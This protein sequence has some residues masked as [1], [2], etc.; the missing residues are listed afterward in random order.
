V[1]LTSLLIRYTGYAYRRWEKALLQPQQTQERTLRQILALQSRLPQRKSQW[2]GG[3]DAQAQLAHLRQLPLQDYEALPDVSQLTH[4]P[5]LFYELTSGSSGAK[6]RIPYTRPLLQSF[7]HMFLCWAHDILI[8]L[9]QQGRP[10]EGGQV[11]FSVSPQFHESPTEAVD[12]DLGLTDDSDYLTGMSARLFQRFRAAP[13]TLRYL[14]EPQHFWDVLALALLRAPQ[15][16]VISVWSPSFLRV[17]Q[18]HLQRHGERLS[19]LLAQPVLFYENHCFPLPVP[20]PVRQ[21]RLSE[22]LR[23]LARQDL[24][25]AVPIWVWAECFPHLKL[26]SAWGAE[27]AARDF[28]AL[29]T[30]FA[31]AHV[32]EKGLL[33]TEAPITIPSEQYGGFLPLPREVFYE[34]VPLDAQGQPLLQE[35]PLL[36]HELSLG[37]AYELVISQKSGLLRYRL[38]DR[39]R[40]TGLQGLT[41]Y[42]RF[43]GRSEALC[44]LVGEKLNAVFV[45]Q[46]VHQC[47]PTQR[48]CVIPQRNPAGYILVAEQAL[49]AE[50]LENYLL[51][52]PHY[53]NARKLGQLAPL[54]LQ[55]I[56]DLSAHLQQF[57][58]TQRHMKWGDIKDQVLYYREHNGQLLQYLQAAARR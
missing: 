46:G 29:R 49:Q 27:N 21:R 53:G 1:I 38:K 10:F 31:F 16:E 37:A 22:A 58:V 4:Q 5:P 3:T 36:L 13:S 57:F 54:R 15:L 20:S 45:A 23:W 47:Y 39:V 32:Q 19:G 34:F 52:S 28:A 14:Q 50:A 35:Q 51:T 18:Q 43:E 17:L 41:P 44:D 25:S 9:Q 8:T 56:P 2:G 26:I 42:L 40:V 48:V 6:K 30:D 11:Y 24:Q 7:T 55:I 12:S 33:A